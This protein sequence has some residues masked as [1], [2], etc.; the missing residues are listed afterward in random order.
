[1]MTHRRCERVLY[2]RVLV[3]CCVMALMRGGVA[4][5]SR[6]LTRIASDAVSYIEPLVFILSTHRWLSVT[7]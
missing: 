2:E 7:Q 4:V 1:M 5:I 6:Q 3:C